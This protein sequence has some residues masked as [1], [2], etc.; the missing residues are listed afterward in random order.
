MVGDTGGFAFGVVGQ[1]TPFLL[2]GPRYSEPFFDQRHRKRVKNYTQELNT[3]ILGFWTLQL[4]AP[5]SN[6]PTRLLP[7]I[8]DGAEKS[9]RSFGSLT[10]DS[11]PPRSNI[12]SPF[13][14]VE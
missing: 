6:K 13:R 10:L 14:S 2:T 4:A 1:D 8:V 7:E 12:A 11:C 3:R 9:E 5:L